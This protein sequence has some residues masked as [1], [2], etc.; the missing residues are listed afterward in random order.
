MTLIWKRKGLERCVDLSCGGTVL[1]HFSVEKLAVQVLLDDNATAQAP[2]P[3]TLLY[4]FSFTHERS[5]RVL[6]CSFFLTRAIQY[7]RHIF[8]ATR[9]DTTRGRGIRWR[10]ASHDSKWTPCNRLC[11]AW[12]QQPPHDWRSLCRPGIQGRTARHFASN[13]SPGTAGARLASHKILE[14]G[15]GA[16]NTAPPPPPPPQVRLGTASMMAQAGGG[17]PFINVERLDLK[18]STASS[19]RKEGCASAC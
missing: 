6:F 4:M 8:I 17:G 7:C 5:I 13:D 18:V 19:A 3:G 1:E 10:H 15:G 2:R 16:P 12:N 14:Y 9:Y 11:A